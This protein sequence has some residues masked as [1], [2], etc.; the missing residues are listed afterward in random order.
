MVFLAI[1][2]ISQ[3]NGGLFGGLAAYGICQ[4]GCNGVTAACYSVRL[5]I[6]KF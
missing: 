3:V 5:K 2:M 6:K 1:L 4:T